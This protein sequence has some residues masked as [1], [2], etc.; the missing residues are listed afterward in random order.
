MSAPSAKSGPAFSGSPQESGDLSELIL[1]VQDLRQRVLNLEARLASTAAAPD[2]PAAAPEV[3]VLAPSLPAW[4]GLPPNTVPVLGRMLVAIAGAYVLRALT[5]W[6]VLPAAAGV[7]IGLIYGLI[8][9][10]VA[11]RSPLEA[12]FAAALSCS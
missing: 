3:S 1:Q 5:D 6:G 9:L 8:W 11:A 7:A 2:V 12:K 4:F 10:W